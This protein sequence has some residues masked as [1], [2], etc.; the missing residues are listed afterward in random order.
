MSC[1]MSNSSHEMRRVGLT[2]TL[3]SQ[4]GHTVWKY[5]LYTYRQFW[6]PRRTGTVEPS[7]PSPRLISVWVGSAW[8]LRNSKNCN[9]PGDI[10]HSFFIPLLPAHKNGRILMTVTVLFED[11]T[12]IAVVVHTGNTHSVKT[13]FS[14]DDPVNVSSSTWEVRTKNS[15]HIHTQEHGKTLH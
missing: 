4:Q 8:H 13:V 9:F 1:A 10:R 14:R 5:I 7:P 3:P 6:Q 12:G 2:S 11:M 15:R